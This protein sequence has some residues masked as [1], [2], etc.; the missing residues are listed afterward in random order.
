[1]RV[2]E[3]A[4]PGIGNLRVMELDIPS[5]SANQLLLRM[6]VVALTLRDYK[7]VTGAYQFEGTSSSVIPSGSGVGE[8]VALGNAVRGFKV[9]DRVAPIFLQAWTEMQ[10]PTRQEIVNATLGGPRLSGLLS[11]FVTLPEDS[12]TRIPDSIDD[13]TASILPGIG[14]VA[15]NALIGPA[16]TPSSVAIL[17]NNVISL[18]AAQMAVALGV[19]VFAIVGSE[20]KR[21]LLE[22]YGVKNIINYR[23]SP[24]WSDAIVRGNDNEGVDTVLDPGSSE[25]MAESIKAVKPGGTVV[26]TGARN[27]PNILISLPYLLAH[28]ISIRGCYAASKSMQKNTIDIFSKY[29]ISVPVVHMSDISGIAGAFESIPK[30]EKHGATLIDMRLA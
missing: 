1:M 14:A 17:V 16:N 11:E 30:N 19:K 8:V 18:V 25:T 6:S 13:E 3:L 27:E 10:M 29:N 12:V 28:N 15:Y 5:P 20:D 22:K 7:V 24:N 21:D 4:G 2:V 9:G 23:N 26:I